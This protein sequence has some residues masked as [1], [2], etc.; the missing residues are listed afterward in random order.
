MET[1]ANPPNQKLLTFVTGDKGGVGKSFFAR[2]LAQHKIDTKQPFRA[3]DIDPVNPNLHQF[4]AEHT[5]AL[6]IDEEGAL[7]AIRNA[8]DAHPQFLVDC[9]ARSIVELD[10]WFHDLGIIEEKKGLHLAITF[11]FVITPDK[12]CTAIMSDALER[13]GHDARYLVVKNLAM[14]R[15]FSIYDQSKLR[16][17]LLKEYDAK[18]IILPRLLERTVVLLDRND[19]DFGSALSGPLTASADRSRV[20]GF[21]NQVYAQLE[22][23]KER[24]TL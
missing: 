11:V 24:L 2:T 6:D 19:L 9:A 8:L 5:T 16:E 22:K 21:L 23:V 13:F 10:G 17:R 20:T 3:F 12:S 15:D 1:T 14:G 7:D 18:E 4:Y